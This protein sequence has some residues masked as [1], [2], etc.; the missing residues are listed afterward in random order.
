[1]A[2]KHFKNKISEQEL[3]CDFVDV[4]GTGEGESVSPESKVLGAVE[5]AAATDSDRPRTTWAGKDPSGGVKGDTLGG[6]VT[7]RAVVFPTKE[8][9]RCRLGQHFH[10]LP[11][12]NT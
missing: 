2:E 11:L 3:N 12:Q 1:M 4:A 6:G 5:G 10:R 7:G 8:P 9:T